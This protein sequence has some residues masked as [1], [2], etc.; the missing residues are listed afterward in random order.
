LPHLEIAV[1][2]NEPAAVVANRGHG[3][4]LVR[5]AIVNDNEPQIVIGDADFA[6]GG[7]F[8]DGVIFAISSVRCERHQRC[9]PKIDNAI[10]GHVINRSDIEVDRSIDFSNARPPFPGQ[11]AIENGKKSLCR[12]RAR[13][14]NDWTRANGKNPV[15]AKVNVLRRTGHDVV[16]A[17]VAAFPIQPGK[18][19]F[20]QLLK[21]GPVMIGG[22]PAKAPAGD[23]PAQ[24]PAGNTPIQTPASGT[25]APALVG[26]LLALNLTPDGKGIVC[27]DPI[28]GKLVVLAYNQTTQ[29]LGGITSI[30]DTKTKGFVALADASGDIPANV[31]G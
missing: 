14:A 9:R 24:T 17:D 5:A 12:R 27:D 13:R 21:N 3:M 19:D 18:T 31:G 1:V 2:E 29:T 20:A 15:N 25:P 10:L 4:I 6:Q 11:R 26:W 8:D 22:A 28:T 23:T 30:F 7:I 16:P